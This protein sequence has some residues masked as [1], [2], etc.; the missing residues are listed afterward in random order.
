M[1]YPVETQVKESNDKSLNSSRSRRGASKDH[2]KNS[3][4]DRSSQKS[5]QS[6]VQPGYNSMQYQILTRRNKDKSKLPGDPTIYDAKPPKVDYYDVFYFETRIRDMFDEYMEPFN[7]TM[8][9]DKQASLQ[10]RHDYDTILERLY[11]LECFAMIQDW[12]LKPSVQFEAM[13]KEAPA[14][15]IKSS[16]TLLKRSNLKNTSNQDGYTNQ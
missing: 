1:V 7:K 15:G 4:L 9:D 16:G 12:K 11:E 2:G 8:R 10:L 13:G 14:K 5:K 6:S 3:T